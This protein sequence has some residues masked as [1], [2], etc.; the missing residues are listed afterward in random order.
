MS[1]RNRYALYTP[2]LQHCDAL[3]QIV[4][5]VE[6]SQDGD[7][8]P[9]ITETIAPDDMTEIENLTQTPIIEL[10][11]DARANRRDYPLVMTSCQHILDKDFFLQY[12]NV[13]MSRNR[14][15]MA[16]VCPVCRRQV[17]FVYDIDPQGALRFLQDRNFGLT[18]DVSDFVPRERDGATNAHDR[19]ER[20]VYLRETVPDLL[21]SARY[22]AEVNGRHAFWPLRRVLSRATK[23]KMLQIL[24]PFR[25]L[26]V[27]DTQN[28]AENTRRSEMQ[29]KV[30][31]DVVLHEV[32][33]AMEAHPDLRRTRMEFRRD[34]A[35]VVCFRVAMW[36]ACNDPRAAGVPAFVP[37]NLA[38]QAALDVTEGELEQLMNL[39]PPPHRADSGN[40]LVL[41]PS[42][43]HEAPPQGSGG[44]QP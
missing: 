22:V 20:D 8:E 36:A 18:R 6:L 5:Q 31:R 2:Q 26:Q 32:V 17:P 13:P 11:R 37:N 4:P 7:A 35:K 14:N 34:I 19:R 1:T 44:G 23:T 42:S 28:Q 40:S 12:T 43:S 21:T 10:L 41:I 38:P 3:G 15:R 30:L 24:T 16:F 9:A 33:Q 39:I 27:F 25:G 29:W